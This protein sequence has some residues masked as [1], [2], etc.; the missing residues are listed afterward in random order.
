MQLKFSKHIEVRF[1]EIDSMGVVWHGSYTLYFED[2]REAFGRKYGLGYDTFFDNGFAAPLVELNMQYK[3]I[4]RYGM[5]PRVD[6]IYRPTE[7]A[8]I[9]FDYEIIDETDGSLIATAHSVQVF[10]D[11]DYQLVW[12]NPEFY[13]KWKE[14]WDVF[15]VNE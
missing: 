15:N 14:R 12:E 13:Q 6:I 9:V 7:S 2:A 10:M 8:K 11:R 4:I 5:L 3:K 1:S